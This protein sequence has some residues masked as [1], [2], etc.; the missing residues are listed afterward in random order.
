MTEKTGRNPNRG[1][2]IVEVMLALALFGV[3]VTTFAASY[4]NIINAISAIQVDQPF[5]QDMSMMRAEAF[6]ISDIEELEEGGEVMT[7]HHGEATWEIECE[8][9]LVADL[10]KVWLN[11]EME[12]RE[13]GEKQVFTEIHFLTRPTW[14]DPIERADLRAE[15]RDRLLARQAGLE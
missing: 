3:A 8:P 2:T 7:G 15:T 13:T 10:F 5:E 9:T 4:L 14:S 11:V 6:S 1:F 12:D